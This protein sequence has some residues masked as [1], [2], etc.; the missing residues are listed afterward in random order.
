MMIGGKGIFIGWIGMVLTFF[1]ALPQANSQ[2][3][4]YHED[5][6]TQFSE[7]LTRIY[8]SPNK[9]ND[10]ALLKL[11]NHR[12]DGNIRSLKLG[13]F[14]NRR[15]EIDGIVNKYY[16]ERSAVDKKPIVNSYIHSYLELG[17]YHEKLQL[18]NHLADQP[19]VQKICVI[20]FSLGSSTLNFLMANPTAS[21][22]VFDN[23]DSQVFTAPFPPSGQEEEEVER[24]RGDP[25][26]FNLFSKLRLEKLIELFPHRTITVIGGK[27]KHSLF[28]FHKEFPDKMDCNLLYLDAFQIFFSSSSSN[29]GKD[30]LDILRNSV[31]LLS[32]QFNRVIIDSVQMGDYFPLWEYFEAKINE[33]IECPSK[34]SFKQRKQCLQKNVMQN[35]QHINSEQTLLSTAATLPCDAANCNVELK[36]IDHLKGFVLTPCVGMYTNTTGGTH[37]E[38]VFSYEQCGMQVDLVSEY[39]ARLEDG[40]NLIYDQSLELLIAELKYL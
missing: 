6:L 28:N 9:I 8:C 26:V 18:L 12:I 1:T 4:S 21:V 32:P 20:G 36:T 24:S 40:S 30:F 13:Q 3:S 25:A 37:L 31:Q 27:V 19:A 15:L 29:N 5:V 14:Y 16:Q 35:L 11:C 2:D 33:N 7:K 38:F 10:E 34:I 39:Q 22:L 23:I 17:H